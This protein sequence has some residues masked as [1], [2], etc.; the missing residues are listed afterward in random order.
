MPRSTDRQQ[1]LS[2]HLAEV[3]SIVEGRELWFPAFNYDYLRSGLFDARTDP[4]QVG[5]IS[6]AFRS[7]RASW[8][9]LVP[10]FSMSGSG[11]P[12]PLAS[13]VP[14]LVD[15]FGEE[16][17]FARLVELDGVVVWYGAPWSS[18]TLIHHAERMVSD[19][20]LYR[21]DKDF[22]GTVISR[23]GRQRVVLR[24]HVRPLDRRSGYDWDALA[25]RVREEGVLGDVPGSAGTCRW[26]PARQLVA[27]WSAI[28]ADDPLGLLDQPS[29]AWAD[30]LLDAMG[31]RFRLEDFED[32][33][34]SLSAPESPLAP[35][36]PR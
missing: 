19:G 29:R 23:E 35:P 34:E 18:T 5:A 7:T 20:P 15:P 4:S 11:P 12:P 21:Y 24:Y 8:R 13:T 32:G 1:L 16:S 28:L 27:L 31:R 10:V 26:A 36:E 33:V 22:P 6:E 14:A 17:M 2:S 3:S 25:Q 9:T 30:P